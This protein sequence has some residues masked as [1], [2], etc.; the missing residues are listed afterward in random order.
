M[1]KAMTILFL[2]FARATIEKT[3]YE[4]H[5]RTLTVC[6]MRNTFQEGKQ[7]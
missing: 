1:S 3:I 4:S 7:Q 5:I 6:K 2:R